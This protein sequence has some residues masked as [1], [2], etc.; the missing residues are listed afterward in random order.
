M[1]ITN[2]IKSAETWTALYSAVQTVNFTSFDYTTIKQ[3]LVTYLQTYYPE[4]FNDYIESSEFIA[5][6]ESFAYVG[7]LIAYR[8]DVNAH[9]NFI[10]VA[11]RKDSI[12]RLA[13][14]ISYNPSR[15]LPNRGLV[16]IQ[17]ISTT[18]HVYDTNGNDLAGVTVNWNDANNPFWKEQFLLI[19][20]QILGQPFGTVAPNERV[21]V[22]DVLFELYTLNNNTLN[23]GV[24]TYNASVSGSSYSMELVPVALDENGPYERTPGL[25]S[26]FSLLYGSDGL[27]DGSDTTGF[28]LFTKQGFLQQITTT[29]DGVTPNQTYEININDIN[30]I[31]LWVN[32]IDSSTGDILDDGSNSTGPSGAW[33]EVDVAYAQN[34]IFNTNPNRNKYE[35]ETLDTDQVRLI[36]GDG[37]FANIPSG[38][39]Q[40]WFRTSYS[41]TLVIP[42]NSINNLTSSFTYNDVNGSVQTFKFSYSLISS[43]QNNSPSEDIEHIRRVAPSVFY[44]Q[45]RMV[46][47]QDYNT[48]MLQDPS[49]LKLKAINRTFAGDS[50]YIAW[51]DPT[52]TYEDVKLFGD[53]LALYYSDSTSEQTVTGVTNINTL[54]SNYI[55]PL[56]SSTDLFVILTSRGV[57]NTEVRR[58]FTTFETNQ[59]TS[60]L[61]TASVS[62]LPATVQLYYSIQDDLWQATLNLTA[63]TITDPLW[64]TTEGL[65]TVVAT[66]TST[67]QVVHRAERLTANSQNIAFWNTNDGSRI[68]TYDTGTSQYDQIVVLKANTTNEETGTLSQNWNFN[69]LSQVMVNGLPDINNLNIMPVDVN[70][71]GI[72]DNVDLPEIVD[73]AYTITTSTAL[74]HVIS[75]PFVALHNDITNNASSFFDLDF[76]YH[77]LSDLVAYP[78]DPVIAATSSNDPLPVGN[79]TLVGGAPDQLDGITLETTELG[80]VTGYMDAGFLT[81]TSTPAQEI[82]VGEVVLGPGY[83][84]VSYPVA[85]DGPNLAAL[86]G[87][88]TYSFGLTVDFGT[89][90]NINYTATGAE[91]IDELIA[92]INTLLTGA[93]L[94]LVD[95]NLQFSSLAL[96]SGSSTVVSAGLIND[97]FGAIQLG[98]TIEVDVTGNSPSTIVSTGT[99]VSGTQ[100]VDFSSLLD[101][102]A[103]AGL[104]LSVTYDFSITVDGGIT[105][106][107]SYTATGIEDVDTVL[108]FITGSLVGS[109]I[110]IASGNLLFTSNTTGQGSTIVVASGVTNDLFAALAAA[111]LV[112]PTILPAVDG[113]TQYSL[114]SPLSVST[115]F[116]ILSTGSRVLVKDQITAIENGIYQVAILGSVSTGTWLRV[117]DAQASL[118]A[119]GMLVYVQQGTQHGNTEWRLDPNPPTNITIGTSDL[120][121]TQVSEPLEVDQIVI[122]NIGTNTSITINVEQ[123]VYFNR[124]TTIDDWIPQSPP[125]V[126][127]ENSV[128]SYLNDLLAHSGDPNTSLWKREHGRYPLN[129]AWFH[130]TPNY[131]LIDP[132]ASNIIDMFIVTNG[133]YSAL[134]NW[135]NGTTAIAPTLP[136][137]LELRTDY[138][139]LLNSAMISD[140]IILHPGK[141]KLLFGSNANQQLQASFAVVR[142]SNGSLTDNQIKVKI[143]QSIRD[144]FN[145]DNWSFGQSFYFTELATKIHNDLLSEIET[146][147]LVPRYSQN[148]FGD[149]FE[150][151]ARDDEILYPSISVNDISIVTSLNPRTIRQSV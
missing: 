6:L 51:H 75:L 87:G 135:L 145:I 65:I 105:Q 62:P 96:G 150:V 109:T 141:F 108:S 124:T 13:K 32:N 70:S 20:N 55:E 113:G 88:T 84:V 119:N 60:V 39:F 98:Y 15:N 44:T 12:L 146:V 122:Q 81:I 2:T 80:T 11:Q 45:D 58:Q 93:T 74:P 136:T 115:R 1:A 16:K 90:Q 72:P 114:D 67:W 53:D 28:F 41:D 49:I 139:Y 31:D 102:S 56:L 33:D 46:N 23:N 42:I 100:T 144:F 147:V 78:K 21:Q 19:L 76:Y 126:G 82:V 110:E 138:G 117:A 69:V 103:G 148:Y 125:V 140:T 9:E 106:N 120:D 57:E 143:V 142:N 112:V 66:S 95:G 91:T 99:D 5:L 18:E 50:K 83:Q 10:T 121:F 54:I 37:E 25:S 29:F 48:F 4:D 151:N 79:V 36:F 17:S 63:P 24:L 127:S 128:T 107:I 52:G 43:L 104:T 94:E 123:F 35:V 40:F 92:A 71:D 89:P 64:S 86:T 7:E 132:A 61:T 137:P 149:L 111:I 8:L 27:G 134:Q 118:V 59:I 26:A 85:L 131:H 38:T 47:G 101:G 34:I 130:Y 22:E 3:S 97:L 73:P 129:F 77:N 116:F 133:Y 30:D 68:I 14:L